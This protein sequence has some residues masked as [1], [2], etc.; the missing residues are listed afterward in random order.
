MAVIE[1]AEEDCN[2]EIQLTMVGNDVVENKRLKLDTEK[3]MKKQLDFAPKD[4]GWA[5]M[6]CLG[7]VKC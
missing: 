4:T 2:S 5:W 7:T 6:C 3:T 1:K